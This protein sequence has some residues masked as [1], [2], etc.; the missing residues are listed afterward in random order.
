MVI[1]VDESEGVVSSRPYRYSPHKMDIIDEQVKQLPD[2]GVIE[3]SESAWRSHLVVVQKKD[4]KTRLCTDF[5]MLNMITRKD[6]FPMPTN[7]KTNSPCLL[8]TRNPPSGQRLTFFQ[9]IISI[10]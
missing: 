10:A 3:P 8:L 4:G 6:K 5:R 7:Q 9:G 1:K 2:L